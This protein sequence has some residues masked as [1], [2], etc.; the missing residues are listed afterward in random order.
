MSLSLTVLGC[1]G[2]YA[3]P[4]GACTGYLVETET[5]SVWLDAGP[6]TLANLQKHRDL[7][8]V[9]ALVLTHEHADHW[10]EV[11]VLI[12]A[13]RYYVKRLGLPVYSNASTR[14]MAARVMDDPIGIAEA[15]DWHT[16]EDGDEIIIG[17]QRWRFGDTLHY[18]PT[19]AVRVD[20]PDR[21]LVFS[22]DTGPGWTPPWDGD[23]PDLLLCESTFAERA[24]NEG[25][26]HLSALE[27]AEVANAC[28]AKR[29]VLTHMAPGQDAAL[30][31]EIASACYGGPVDVAVVGASFQI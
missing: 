10:L 15:F 9:D 4:D 30:H 18:V 7:A 6:G 22:S 11:P 25:I 16:V 2:S 14:E 31:A 5:T 23:A 12:N 24:G 19:L 26:Q 1:S 3:G 28:A 8:T 21:C 13:L 20:T 17:D 29:L 27:A